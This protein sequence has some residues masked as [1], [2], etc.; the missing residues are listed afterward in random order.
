MKKCYNFNSLKKHI[1]TVYRELIDEATAN[2]R[3]GGMIEKREEKLKSLRKQ[4]KEKE[5]ILRRYRRTQELYE[6]VM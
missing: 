1:K 3:L 2:R 4:M 5:E 6:H